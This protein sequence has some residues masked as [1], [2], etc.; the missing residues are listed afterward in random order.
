MAIT[1]ERN[2]VDIS[3][4]FQ[5]GKQVIIKDKQGNDFFT[6]YLRLVGDAELNRARI[7]ALRKSAELRRKLKEKDTEERLAFV[8]DFESVDKERLIQLI[9]YLSSREISMRAVENIDIPF[10]KEPP[11]DAT[12]EEQEKYQ[13]EIDDWPR[14][15]EDK[16]KAFIEAEMKKMES[17]L[18]EKSKEDIYK[19]YEDSAIA[20]LCEN[21]MA[22]KFRQMCVFLGLYRDEKFKERMFNDFDTFDNLFPEFKQQFLEEY[23]R[24]E[25]STDELKK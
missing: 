1:P 14:I 3:K 8:A 19:V 13:K 6:C 7:F 23:I 9:I 12:L 5:W 10:P 11:D 2:D 15:R 17:S 16:I 20:D 22:N 21:E 18:Q 24:L 4:L 25:L